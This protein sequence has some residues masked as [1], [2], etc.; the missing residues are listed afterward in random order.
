MP[1]PGLDF[2]RYSRLVLFYD[3]GMGEPLEGQ[4]F[5]YRTLRQ[6]FSNSARYL[7]HAIPS[8]CLHPWYMI[9][10]PPPILA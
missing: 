10:S 8:V 3:D 5:L 6:E 9:K 2:P 1:Q 7:I 4:I